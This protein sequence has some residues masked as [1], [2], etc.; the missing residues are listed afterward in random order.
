MKSINILS[1]VQANNNLSSE[2]FAS[3]TGH[4]GI[5]I[6]PNEIVDLTQLI[7]RMY[8]IVPFVNLF[9]DFYVGYKIQHI[10]KEFDLLRFGDNYIINIELK[11]SSKEE[12]IQKQLIR[13]KYYLSHIKKVVHNFTYVVSTNTLYQLNANDTLD[14]VDFSLLIQILTNQNLLKIE[15]PDSLFNPSDYLVSP[16][17]STQKF[18]NNNYFLTNQQEEFKNN[19]LKRFALTCP[20]FIAITGSAGTGKT[21]L[22]YDIAKSLMG[23]K[24]IVIVHCGNL[25]EGH[26][27]LNQQGWNIV[28]I[29]Y[30]HNYNLNN[31]DLVIIDEAQRIYASQ[32]EK[33]IEDAK[34][35]NAKILFS[36]DKK[37]TLSRKETL[38]DIDSRIDAIPN[39]IKYNLSNKIR[40]NKEIASF[41][42]LLFNRKRTDVKYL[43]CGNVDFDYFTDAEDVKN[44]T[45]LIS[46]DG[47]E[48]L[49]L[50]PSIHHVEHH[51]SYSDVSSKCSHAV[52][53][54][55][56]DNVAVIIDEYYSYDSQGKLIYNTHT[57]Y[58][59]VK[60]LFQNITRTRKRLKLIIISNEQVLNQCIN[61]LKV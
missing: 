53:G 10:S 14:K 24:R 42:K 8:Q 59:S 13:N 38:V 18:L 52:I 35:S 36:Y 21:L 9:N 27:R 30:F 40:T 56:F 20:D 61:I 7:D 47:W 50:T 60:M 1:L 25:N 45:R 29:K 11:N 46:N 16:F 2:S 26:L 12:K 22:T 37:Q 32:F 39:I 57:Y 51:E 48:V 43:G 23:S 41:I 58:D 5:E 31:L 17:N 33:L 3:Y 6:K 44:Y 54:Q 55:E 19:I 34:S 4:Y 15:N 49:R 28:A